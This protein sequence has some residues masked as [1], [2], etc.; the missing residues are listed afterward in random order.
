MSR[1]REPQRFVCVFFCLSLSFCRGS[2]T[3]RRVGS[4]YLSS[5]I[6]FWDVFLSSNFSL[7]EYLSDFWRFERYKFW[8]KSSLFASKHFH[9]LDLG[10][11]NNYAVIIIEDEFW[12]CLR[13]GLQL[14]SVTVTDVFLCHRI[15]LSL[16]WRFLERFMT[17]VFFLGGF[18]VWF[19]CTSAKVSSTASSFPQV[20]W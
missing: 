16:Y 18:L 5:V 17:L 6:F 15:H 12:F 8:E 1:K 3:G 10:S 13:P 20:K 14:A 7:S 9:H 19:S 11:S 2:K 4:S